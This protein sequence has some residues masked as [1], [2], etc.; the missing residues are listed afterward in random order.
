MTETDHRYYLIIPVLIFICVT[1]AETTRKLPYNYICSKWTVVCT[2]ASL[3]SIQSRDSISTLL[4]PSIRFKSTNDQCGATVEIES[5][6]CMLMGAATVDTSKELYD[7]C[8]FPSSSKT[9]TSSKPRVA[10]PNPSAASPPLIPTTASSP[11]PSL[12]PRIFSSTSWPANS[13]QHFRFPSHPW[14]TSSSSQPP[15]VDSS[16]KRPLQQWLWTS[17]VEI[18]LLNQ[19]VH[20]CL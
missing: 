19:T 5:R 10:A 18:A 16:R 13:D 9:P 3:I 1:A 12:A 8:R 7:Y 20:N 4:C 15:T 17:T 6:N 14:H 2:V 11:Y